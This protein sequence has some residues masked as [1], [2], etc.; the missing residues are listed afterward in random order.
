MKKVFLSIAII[1]LVFTSSITAQNNDKIT[2]QDTV[3]KQRTE[4]VSA[5]KTSDS[6]KTN[7]VATEI[8]ETAATTYAITPS[9]GFS[10]NSL[11]RGILGMLSLIFIAFLFS[12]NKK[13]INWKIV[14]IG[15]AFQLF[16]A[17]GV[18]KV[19]FIKSMFEFVGSLFVSVL[20]F[21]RAGSKFLFEGLV[22]DMDTFGFIFAFQVLP[23]IIFFSITTIYYLFLDT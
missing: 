10:I 13:A 16:I 6:L 14:G 19:D 8:L 22:V 18:L 15:L 9:Q 5:T 1:L 23:T 3:S 17:I 21:T 4:T 20:E 2:P 12:S 11:W 7:A